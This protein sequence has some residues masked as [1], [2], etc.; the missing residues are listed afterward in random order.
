MPR[1]KLINIAEE[2]TYECDHINGIPD[3]PQTDQ[4]SRG[5]NVGF[6]LRNFRSV[7]RLKLIN[8]AEES[9]VYRWSG[10][11]MV[12]RLKLINIAEESTFW[13][14][15]HERVIRPPQTDQHSRGI[16]V[17]W[18]APSLLSQPPQTDQHSRGINAGS[19]A[20]GRASG[21]ASN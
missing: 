1:L 2:S 21:S 10:S 4:H 11:A 20:P 12:D 16:N 13:L 8:I 6:S 9:T 3:P 14:S 19:A 17:R 15:F 5:I 7:R 18:F